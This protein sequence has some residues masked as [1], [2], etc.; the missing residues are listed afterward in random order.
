MTN[1]EP[2]FSGG[3]LGQWLHERRKQATER[4]M[5]QTADSLLATP[6]ADVVANLINVAAVRCPT[7]LRSDA[8]LLDPEEV[9]QEFLEFGERVTRRVTR[10]TLVVPYEGP[11]QIFKLR[12]TSHTFSFPLAVVGNQELRVFSNDGDGDPTRVNATFNEQLDDIE[13]YLAWARNDIDQHHWA[14]DH[15]LPPKVAAR[16]AKFLADRDLHANIGFPIKR[17]NDA[18]A[19]VVP[20]HRRQLAPHTPTVARGSQTF[21]P[22]PTL[23]DSDY[24]AALAVLRNARNALERSPS[25]T[26]HLTEEEIRDLLLVS[27]NAQFEGAAAGE[28]FNGR[29][30]TDILVRVNDTN[31]FIGE[32]KFWK[33]PKTVSDALDQLLGYVTWRDTKAALLLFIREADV[34]SVMAKAV[35][36][37]EEH[38]N[39]KRKGKHANDE[40]HD[41]VLHASGDPTREIHLALLPFVIGAKE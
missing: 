13:Q 6:E 24:E 1:P 19:H 26:A 14:L 25:T 40:R 33:S 3:D 9:L 20:L 27:L 5:T 30:K 37:V 34:S 41:F 32:C 23:V 4:L 10:F 28:V 29:G 11:F 8:Y 35:A 21:T 36:K 2:L 22:E 39:Y 17:R 15:D 12:P 31:V 38:P 18:D 7:I 16:R